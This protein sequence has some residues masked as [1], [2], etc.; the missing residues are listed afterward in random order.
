MPRDGKGKEYVLILSRSAMK[1]SKGTYIGRGKKCPKCKK[2]MARMQRKKP[3][4]PDSNQD[5]WFSEWDFCRDCRHVQHY[6][7]F[8]RLTREPAP[9]ER[10]R[11]PQWASKGLTGLPCPSCKEPMERRH[12]E[13]ATDWYQGIW[14]SEWDYCANWSCRNAGK[15]IVF[16]E[17]FERQGQA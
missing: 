9:I 17:A 7:E 4:S 1:M 12:R 8:R 5:T 14:H 15:H 10:E 2:P 6:E 3:P 11:W 16:Y 13:R